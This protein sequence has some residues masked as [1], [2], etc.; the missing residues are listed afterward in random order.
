[1]K[2][3]SP[4][5]H[6]FIDYAVVLLFALAPTLFGFGGTPRVACYVLAAAHLGMTLL[7]AF[8]LGAL[9]LIPFTVH[10][11]LEGVIAVAL[12]ALPWVLGFDEMAPARN[13]FLASAVAVALT[14]LI[15]DYKAGDYAYPPRRPRHSLA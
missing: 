14:W 6:G 7:T 5:I 4:R 13:F 10:G 2:I 3:L 8:P 9:K 12:A 11:A 15:T 1:M